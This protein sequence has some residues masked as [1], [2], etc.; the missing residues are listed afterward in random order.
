MVFLF[1]EDTINVRFNLPSGHPY[2]FLVGRFCLY[3]HTRRR[4][5]FPN[6]FSKITG[7]I[8]TK[9]HVEP[10][11]VGGMKVC[12][13]GLGHMTKMA[14]T[15]VYGKNH[16]KILFSRTKGPMTLGLGMQHWGH[17]PNKVCSNDDLGMTLTFFYGKVKFASLGFHM[18]KY[19]FLQGKCQKV[20]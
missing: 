5:P 14:A 12:S 18:G 6:I 9:F 10:P 15:P 1:V 8:E 3:V 11:W 19:T 17:G 13:G 7:P 4:P 2:S 16:L 20:I